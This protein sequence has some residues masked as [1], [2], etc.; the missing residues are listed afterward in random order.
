MNDAIVERRSCAGIFRARLPIG[1]IAVVA[2][3]L[4]SFA[5]GRA[6]AQVVGSVAA[7]EPNAQVGRDG[8]WG[9]LQLGDEIR[10][11]D[12]VRTNES[13]RVK[14]AFGDGSVAIVSNNS[15]LF[16]DRHVYDPS[17]AGGSSLLE[18]LK[19]KVR[20]I[21]SDYYSDAGEY[22]VKTPNATAGVRGTDF[23]VAY[24]PVTEVTDV[25]TASGR[26]YVRSLAA[27]MAEAVMVTAGT[28]TTIEQGKAPTEPQSVGDERFHQYMNDV[29]FIGRGRSESIGLNQ[30]VLD[31]SAVPQPERADRAV[32]DGSESIDLDELKND[33]GG[34]E[35][36]ASGLAEQPPSALDFG[37]VG[38]D[39]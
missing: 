30:P 12:R 29:E 39:F 36:D 26:V 10:M 31:G 17:Q 3:V 6:H 14:I 25:I 24:D 8:G 16:I 2:F 11:S 22:E 1:R 5:V 19:G 13:G 21:V 27:T 23:I 32:V 15:D 9:P 35:P 28:E 4:M 18:L 20:T 38:V 37:R 7:L 33:R 34:V